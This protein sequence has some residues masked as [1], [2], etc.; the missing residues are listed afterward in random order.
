LILVPD[1]SS[2]LAAIFPDE[3]GSP[4]VLDALHHGSVVAPSI[5]P[6]EVANSILIG[7]RRKRLSFGEAVSALRM[8]SPLEVELVT[9]TVPE[10]TDSILPLAHKHALTIYDALYLDLARSR[11]ARLFSIDQA[12]CRAARQEGV[13]VA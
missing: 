5:W 7:V 11:S 9:R 3:Q 12:L 13:D 1:A 4:E 2:V 10:I 6:A 8:L